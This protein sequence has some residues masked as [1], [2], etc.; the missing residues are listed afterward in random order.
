MKRKV[1]G[2]VVRTP[3]GVKP[4]GH[5]WVFIRKRNENNEIVRYKT[6][7]VAQGFSQRPKIDY[8][9][10]YSPVVDSTTFR[11]L[12]SLVIQKGIDM[13]LMDVVTTCLFIWVT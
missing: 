10:T 12:I 7:L 13:H 11:Y 1:F 3:E 2:P 4:F 8:D 5:K 6:R 9:E